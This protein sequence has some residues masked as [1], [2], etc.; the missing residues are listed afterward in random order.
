MN[1]DDV[2]ELPVPSKNWY[3]RHKVGQALGDS[4][5]ATRSARDDIEQQERF[6]Y[7]MDDL[8]DHEY[9]AQV[10]GVERLDLGGSAVKISQQFNRYEPIPVLTSRELPNFSSVTVM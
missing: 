2:G 7:L 9:Q 1:N 10:N 6:S 5:A 3:A 8:E 4:A